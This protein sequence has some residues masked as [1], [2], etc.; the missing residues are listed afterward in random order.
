[1]R[2]SLNQQATKANCHSAKCRLI[3]SHRIFYY[4]R[5]NFFSCVTS[6]HQN[7]RSASTNVINQ[8]PALQKFLLIFS[9][10]VITN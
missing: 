4:Q 6:S 1:M 5:L 9:A 2:D 8:K 7:Y 3:K 10:I